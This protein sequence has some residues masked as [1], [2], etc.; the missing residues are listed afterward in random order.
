MESVRK[1]CRIDRRETCFL[2]FTLESY[3]GIAV[4]TTI[5]PEAG[6]VEFYIPPG[7]EAELETILEDLKKDIMIEPHK[8][9]A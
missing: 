3:E 2:R 7:R 4:M 9:N 8:C 6:L 1:Y 5:D